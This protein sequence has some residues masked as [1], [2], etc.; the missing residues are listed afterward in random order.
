MLRAYGEKK[1]TYS[2]NGASTLDIT[3]RRVNLD[4]IDHL[5]QKSIKMHQ[6]PY[7]GRHTSMFIA[8]LSTISRYGVGIDIYHLMHR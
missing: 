8:A 3:T 4:S 5:S 1:V 2:T 7:L 6:K